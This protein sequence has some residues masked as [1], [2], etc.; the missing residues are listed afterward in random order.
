[1]SRPPQTGSRDGQGRPTP[2][3]FYRDVDQ[4]LLLAGGG[5]SRSDFGLYVLTGVLGRFATAWDQLPLP[6]PGRPE[7]RVL[8]G[9]S[10]HLGAYAIEGQMAWDGVIELTSLSVDRIDAVEDVP[11]EDD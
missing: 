6:I 2:D 9:Y 3:D 7:Y 4:A 8:I 5:L 11:G 1:M 10:V